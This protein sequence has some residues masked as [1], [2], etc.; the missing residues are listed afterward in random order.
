M[1][2]LEFISDMLSRIPYGLECIVTIDTILGK[3]IRNE[4]VTNIYKTPQGNWVYETEHN[5]W[6]SRYDFHTFKPVLRKMED[7][8]DAEYDDLRNILNASYIGPK[9]DIGTAEYTNIYQITKF[10]EYCKKHNLDN[11]NWNEKLYTN[12]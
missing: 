6:R 4:T 10:I 7:I 9:T 1:E 3:Q 8:T 11:Y 12:K 2:N 5:E